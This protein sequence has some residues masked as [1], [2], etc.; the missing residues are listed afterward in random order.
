MKPAHSPAKK[1]SARARD[2]EGEGAALDE[3]AVEEGC[4]AAGAE[5]VATAMGATA[6]GVTAVGVTAVGAAAVGAVG[7][8]VA[9]GKGE[10]AAHAQSA[11]ARSID[12]K[13]SR[14]NLRIQS[15]L[16][17]WR[18]MPGGEGLNSKHHAYNGKY[19]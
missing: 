7:W 9:G 8:A 4:L 13:R 2:G 12:I 1:F 14:R 3:A 11:S 5:G 19:P 10:P 18:L 6:V 17:L 15:V 16:S